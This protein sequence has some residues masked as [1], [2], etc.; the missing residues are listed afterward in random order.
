V[1][2]SPHNCRGRSGGEHAVWETSGRGARRNTKNQM[3]QISPEAIDGYVK[4]ESNE[5]QINQMGL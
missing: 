2:L 5:I 3:K 1:L 4:K